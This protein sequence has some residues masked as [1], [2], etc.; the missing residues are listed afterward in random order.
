MRVGLW[1]ENEMRVWLW[2]GFICNMGGGWLLFSAGVLWREGRY[3][4]SVAEVMVA[5]LLLLF[6]MG[7]MQ[8]D[9]AA[10]R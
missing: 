9:G 7:F 2:L 3:Q 1:L 8:N 10:G 4:V 6:G 5:I